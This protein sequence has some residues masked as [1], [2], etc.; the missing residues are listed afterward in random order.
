MVQ[1][2]WPKLLLVA[3]ITEEKHEALNVEVDG[4][5][6]SRR[7]C[8]YGMVRWVGG[9]RLIQ[10]TKLA[11]KRQLLAGT[12]TVNTGSAGWAPIKLIMPG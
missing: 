9:G 5:W 4:T 8:V 11:P 7:R 1:V 6:Q 12:G 10:A 2:G 3:V